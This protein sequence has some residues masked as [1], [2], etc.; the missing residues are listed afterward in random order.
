MTRPET[1][2]IGLLTVGNFI[3]YQCSIFA[4]FLALFPFPQLF[5]HVIFRG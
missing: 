5:V 4:K 3:D 1:L 2:E